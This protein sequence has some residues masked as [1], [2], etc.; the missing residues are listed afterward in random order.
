MDLLHWATLAATLV[1][2][3]GCGGSS[4]ACE[5]DEDCPASELC[6]DG[7][8]VECRTDL[9]CEGVCVDGSCVA[10]EGDGECAGRGDV[11]MLPV[12]AA[13]RCVECREATDCDSAGIDECRDGM[14]VQRE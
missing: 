1:A 11:P 5:G 12:C 2:G 10:C 3:I 8:C 13:G 7:S 9:A 14:C 6:V 4:T